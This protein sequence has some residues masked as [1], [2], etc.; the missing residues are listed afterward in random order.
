M[1]TVI[2]STAMLRLRNKYANTEFQIALETTQAGKI[3]KYERKSALV[4]THAVPLTFLLNV[5]F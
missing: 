3:Y 4:K 1:E 2:Y 5:Y